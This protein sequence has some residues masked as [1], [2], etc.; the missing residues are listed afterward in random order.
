MAW[1]ATLLGIEDIGNTQ[2]NLS[3]YTHAPETHTNTKQQG[4]VS[5]HVFYCGYAY[6]LLCVREWFVEALARAVCVE[7]PHHVPQGRHRETHT[8]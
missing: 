3:V 8:L 1:A 6:C 7:C 5:I 2:A 4:G